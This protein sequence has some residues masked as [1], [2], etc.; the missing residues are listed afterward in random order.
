VL[1]LIV[2]GAIFFGVATATEAAAVGIV[3][4][5]GDHRLARAALVAHA[6][7]RL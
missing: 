2:I 5:A 7:R 6:A 4:R 3:G 1:L